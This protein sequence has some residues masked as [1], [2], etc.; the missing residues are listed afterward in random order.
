MRTAAG[1]LDPV[2]RQISALQ[3]E[4]EL[5]YFRKHHGLA[6]CVSLSASCNA[7]RCRKG[8]WWA[9]AVQ[10]CRAQRCHRYGIL[11][12]TLRRLFATVVGVTGYALIGEA[13]VGHSA[14]RLR[15][16]CFVDLGDVMCPSIVCCAEIEDLRWRWIEERTCRDGPNVSHSRDAF[17][18]ADSKKN[19]DH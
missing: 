7:A 15:A 17:R 16:L 19:T 13:I 6:G 2:S 4:S 3:I 18:K 1:P 14:C 9:S 5:L 11:R 12:V 10:G 8:M